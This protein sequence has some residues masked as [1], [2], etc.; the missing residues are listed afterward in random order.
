[1]QRNGEYGTEFIKIVF[2]DIKGGFGRWNP[3]PPFLSLKKVDILP[4][5]AEL[6]LLSGERKP[7]ILFVAKRRIDK[8]LIL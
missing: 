4:L 7:L 5:F 8:R 1:M 3:K 6:I 2:G